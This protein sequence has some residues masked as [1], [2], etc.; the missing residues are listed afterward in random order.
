MF[1]KNKNKLE[2]W[3]KNQQQLNWNHR[4]GASNTLMV[5]MS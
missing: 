3:K 1:K 2:N 5:D 4:E